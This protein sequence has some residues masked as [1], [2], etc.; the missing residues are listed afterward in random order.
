MPLIVQIDRRDWRH[1]TPG[2]VTEQIDIEGD[3]ETRIMQHQIHIILDGERLG[4]CETNRRR[5]FA[6]GRFE[7]HRR[8]N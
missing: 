4:N 6:T 7:G 1:E 5:R 2:P 3:L 8:H